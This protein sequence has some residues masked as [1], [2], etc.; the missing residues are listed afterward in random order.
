M[1]IIKTISSLPDTKQTFD[2]EN[3]N[4]WGYLSGYFVTTKD[5]T[6]PIA[7][8]TD[9]DVWFQKLQDEEITPLHFIREVEYID[10]ETP[11][12]DSVQD[13]PIK[14]RDG[15]YRR[16][17]KFTWTLE[18]HQYVE[19]LS[20][21]DL[22]IFE[23]DRNN[24][25]KGTTDD[26]VNL[27]GFKTDSIWL[28]KRIYGTESQPEFSILDIQIA[29][30]E[31][32]NLRGKIIEVD[33]TVTDIDR[34][35]INIELGTVRSDLL[36]FT[37]TYLGESLIGIENSDVTLTDDI[38]GVINAATFDFLSG[39]YK[40]SN[41]DKS[42]VQGKLEINSSIYLGCARYRV[43]VVTDVI[44]N[45]ILEDNNNMVTEIGNNMILEN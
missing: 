30:A 36:T 43:S 35:F 3:L 44:I 42:L 1:A 34:L 17:A 25:I 39:L 33:W 45:M 13:L 6:I 28:E 16:K 24:R 41:F 12:L 5:C 21:T 9:F 32:Y 38:K 10:E 7:D 20:G 26:G 37:A 23:Y 15:K 29:D 4:A 31:E 18:K 14:L 27:R 19:E 40:M 8:A 22:Y 2:N 11:Y